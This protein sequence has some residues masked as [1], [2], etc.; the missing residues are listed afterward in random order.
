MKCSV[1]TVQ[2][3][4]FFSRDDDYDDSVSQKEAEKCHSNKMK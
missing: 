1:V 2:Y 4:V 3:T